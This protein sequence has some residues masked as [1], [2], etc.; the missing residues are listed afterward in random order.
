[1]PKKESEKQRRGKAL[2]EML[3]INWDRPG[4]AF[5]EFEKRGYK[6]N[7]EEKQ[8]FKQ[9]KTLKI[10]IEWNDDGLL[11]DLA[12][13][14]IDFLVEHDDYDFEFANDY[15][16]TFIPKE[17]GSDGKPKGDKEGC[18]ATILYFNDKDNDEIVNTDPLDNEE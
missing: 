2:A 11:E 6:W 17:F 13:D 8:W 15:V 1:M 3:N 9:A 16:K 12:Q 10:S 5:K 4:K 18:E 7:S 14:L